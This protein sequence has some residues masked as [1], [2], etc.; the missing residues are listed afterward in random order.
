LRATT[1]EDGTPVTDFNLANTGTAGGLTMTLGSLGVVMTTDGDGAITFLGQ[2][3]GADEDFNINLDDTSDKIVF[4]SSTSANEIQLSGLDILIGG[5]NINT[6]NIAL[7]VGDATT[8]SV[9]I[10]TDGTGTGEVVLPDESISTAEI[11]NATITTTDISGSAGITAAQTALTAGRSLTLSTNDI[12]AD[13]ELYTKTMTYRLPASPVATDDDKSIW[14]NDTANGFTITKLWC[15]SDQTVTMMLQVDD[16]TPS[17]VDTVDLV[18]I[19]T[20][21]T[22]TSL[23]GDVTVAAGDRIDLDVAS[24]SGTPTW[25]VISFTGTWDD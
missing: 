2:S 25:A 4:S 13:A 8:D 7:V 12:L 18:C 21:D 11:A 6:G 17:D 15:E 16:G 24:V 9:T 10:T 23:D 3:T 5:G 19:S 22:D 20:P 14:I 1:D